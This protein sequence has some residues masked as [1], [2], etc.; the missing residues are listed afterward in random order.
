MGFATPE[1]RSS[2]VTRT[3]GR[4]VDLHEY[5]CESDHF[6]WLRGVRTRAWAT[7]KLQRGGV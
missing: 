7:E 4:S 1:T 2:P 6:P 3:T 5:E